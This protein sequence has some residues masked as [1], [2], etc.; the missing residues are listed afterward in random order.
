MVA[1]L[2]GRWVRWRRGSLASP[3]AAALCVYFFFLFFLRISFGACGVCRAL[4]CAGI[5]LAL[6]V[7]SGLW[8]VCLWWRWC[9]LRRRVVPSFC[10]RAGVPY[11]MLLSVRAA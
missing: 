10:F 9:A 3:L 1:S 5:P 4:G 2:L 8:Y 6:H 11:T 7:P